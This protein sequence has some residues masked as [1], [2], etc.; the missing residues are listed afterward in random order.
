MGNPLACSFLEKHFGAPPSVRGGLKADSP[1]RC[2]A[3]GHSTTA[4]PGRL[5][6]PLARGGGSK[7]HCYLLLLRR[8]LRACDLMLT[9]LLVL[10]SSARRACVFAALGLLGTASVWAA[11]NDREVLFLKK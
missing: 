4:A 7:F 8:A 1:G 10:R 6:S 9:N 5:E 11:H 3:V 2:A